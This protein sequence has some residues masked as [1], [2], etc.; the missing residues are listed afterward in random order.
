MNNNKKKENQLAVLE[1][2]R[3]I[4]RP[5]LN[6]EKHADFIFAPAHSKKLNRSR[7][8]MWTIEL[9]QG[10]KSASYL[11]LEPVN[12]RTPTTKTRKVYLVLTKLWEEH[13]KDDETLVFSS[14]E[15]A[16]MLG[17]RWAGKKTAQEIYKE[18][19]ILRTCP[20]TWQYSFM[21]SEGN[22]MQLLD[23]I[24]I[25]DKFTYVTRELRT[26]KSEQF[27]AMHL[28]RFSEPILANLKNN[29]TKP[30]QLET[31]L[32]IKGEIASALY[33]RLDIVL[34]DKNY[35]QRTTQGVFEDLQLEGEIE[36]RYPSGRKR[37]L[38]K[39]LK[40]LNGKRISTGILHLSLEKTSNGSDWKLIA[41]KVGP[42]AAN[43]KRALGKNQKKPAN[44]SEL[45]SLLAK[46]IA[47]VVGDYE[48]RRRLYETYALHYSA[49]LI[50]QALS[51]YKADIPDPK[52]PGRVFSSIL[53]RLAHQ[54]GKEWIRPCATDCKY[55]S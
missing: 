25:L 7:K 31:V 1:Q 16:D 49:E 21:D 2:A 28:I 24:N 13:R 8:K 44:P 32:H 18:I 39:A 14:R 48:N 36:Y 19:Q 10:I 3:S 30:T 45:V 47:A 15:V 29:K 51:E 40:E 26:T 20:F 11:L 50:Y 52:N 55:R 34:S 22:K 17:I 54:H 27:Q 43:V 53:H 42:L 4:V 46:D 35:Y 12:G 9:D 5:E 37:K 23:H 6:I 33:A 41:C 38:E